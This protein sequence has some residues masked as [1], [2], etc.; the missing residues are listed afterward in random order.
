MPPDI[1]IAHHRLALRDIQKA[2]NGETKR[3]LTSIA[4]KLTSRFQ[5]L[6]RMQFISE[7]KASCD[8]RTTRVDGDEA[9]G[10]PFNFLLLVG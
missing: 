2:K 1:G 7:G 6:D 5:K 8:A 9:S 10:P 4:G 3:M